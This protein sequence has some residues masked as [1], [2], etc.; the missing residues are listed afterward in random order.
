MCNTLLLVVWGIEIAPVIGMTLLE[1][2][3]D[4]PYCHFDHWDCNFLSHGYLCC[5][6]TNNQTTTLNDECTTT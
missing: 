3:W 1:I 5:Q 2:S 6:P 4:H